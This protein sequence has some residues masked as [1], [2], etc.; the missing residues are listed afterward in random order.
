MTLILKGT[1]VSK[2]I[3]IGQGHLFSKGQ[4]NVE[5]EF[6]KKNLVTK[7]KN[8]F[9]LAIKE[10]LDQFE[11]IK[12]NVNPSI[13]R[14]ATMFLDTH[15]YLVKDKG[16]LKNIRKNITTKKFSAEWAVYSELKK[17]KKS[18]ENIGDPY[19]KQRIDDISH[20]VLKILENLANKKIKPLKNL[21]IFKKCIIVADDLTP[22]DVLIM[23]ES[24]VLGLISEFGGASSHSSILTRSLEIPTVVG[25]KNVQSI[26]KDKDIIILDGNEGNIILNPDKKALTY[27]KDLQKNYLKEKKALS[28]VLKKSNV[29]LDKKNVEIMINLELPQELKIINK[30][31]IDGIG[32]FRTEYLYADRKDLPTEDEQFAAYK[33]IISKMKNLPVIFRT[34]DVGSDKEVSENIKTGS[35]A[36][37]PALGLRGIRHSLFEK[38]IFIS[39]IKAILRA[40]YFGR[41]K[42]LLPMIT[43]LSEVKASL[44]LI[45]EAKNKL[46]SEKK[47]FSSDFEI[48]IMIEVPS[49]AVLAKRFAKHVDFFSIGTNDLVQYTLAIDRID[50]EV[51]YLY[52]P[53]NSA[54]LSLVKMTID[55]GATNNIPVAIC[56]EMAGDSKYTRLLMGMGLTS[57]SMHPSAIPEVKNIITNTDTT[58]IQKISEQ[59]M[60]SDDVDEKNKLLKILNS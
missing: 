39:Q 52:D 44:N 24:N 4:P 59:I 53:L 7:E 54:V 36:K 51:N 42:I 33:K 60:N 29:T 31:N 13:Q 20:I 47:K 34:L 30:T 27:Y 41:I 19:I 23:H 8:R 15:I 21:K 5:E 57:F 48:G 17:M 10:T 45:A 49:S 2:G 35:V 28:T 50:D 9:D 55:A 12:R 56:G 25:A 3:A 40:G 26:I 16:F 38:N 46:E 32:L 11:F 43:N 14:N 22:T 1:A 37:N 58:K 6:I 18:F